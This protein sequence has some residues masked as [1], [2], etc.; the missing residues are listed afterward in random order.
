MGV[1][2]VAVAVVLGLVTA[3]VNDTVRDGVRRELCKLSPSLGCPGPPGTQPVTMGDPDEP[4]GA[5]LTNL[6]SRYGEFTAIGNGRIFSILSDGGTQLQLRRYVNGNGKPDTWQVWDMS[7][8]D[9]GGGVGI[10]DKSR[11]AFLNAGAWATAEGSKAEIYEFDNEKEAREFYKKMENYRIG[12]PIKVA[13][14]TNPLT[15]PAHWLA[16]HLPFG[17]GDRIGDQIGANEPD[18]KPAQEYWDGGLYN[19][20]YNDIQLGPLPLSIVGKNFGTTSAG[21]WRTYAQGDKKENTTFYFQ[22]S[23]QIMESAEAD[24]DTMIKKAKKRFPN[25]VQNRISDVER[26]LADKLGT[27]MKLPDPV[28]RAIATDSG[29]GI[30]L[31]G[32]GSTWIGIT[33]DENG[34]PVEFTQIDDKQGSWHLR[35]DLDVGPASAWYQNSQEGFRER[36]TK[37]LDLTKPEDKAAFDRYLKTSVQP[38]AATQNPI[39]P[40][41]DLNQMF[42][43]GAGTMSTVNFDNEV[44]TFNA[45]IGAVVVG[46]EWE[47]D[48]TTSTATDASYWKPGTGWVKWDKCGLG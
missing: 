3:G 37:V 14:R 7:W 4:G 19:G 10:P 13:V 44:S 42:L 36:T 11:L 47:Y 38:A 25:S 2:A 20:F 28:K 43:D 12:D 35:A 29:V 46:G 15:G 16:G 8:M 5:C 17:I 23:Q 18:R 24:I 41:R 45:S 26:Q 32:T 31:R 21:V 22:G 33:V 9:V 39:K 48:Q 40:F 34:K 30:G 27:T 6:H 1:L